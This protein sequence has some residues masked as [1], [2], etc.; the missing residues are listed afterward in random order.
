M[1][2]IYTEKGEEYKVDDDLY[3]ALNKVTWWCTSRGHAQGWVD[4]EFVYMHWLVLEG[5]GER[6][7]DHIDG[8]PTNNQLNN[9][10]LV[11]YTQNA[12]NTK[13]QEGTTSLYKGVS[14]YEKLN[15]WVMKYY[16]DKRQI[17][18]G[19]FEC[20]HD[21]AEAYNTEMFRMHGEYARLNVINRDEGIEDG[22]SNSNQD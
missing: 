16:E 10:R 13:K 8:D 11:T 2:I 14:W 1:R 12:V 4:G 7:Y 21:A 5:D 22:Q 9:L 15:K 20:Q 18:G 6:I 3:E 17:H 19:Y